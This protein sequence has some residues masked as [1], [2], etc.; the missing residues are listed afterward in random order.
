MP[1]EEIFPARLADESAL[2]SSDR[3]LRGIQAT[4][5]KIST[6]V[7]DEQS[8]TELSIIDA[9]LS[10]LASRDDTKFYRDF[11]RAERLLLE[12]GLTLL[13]GNIGADA[14]ALIEAEL[15]TSLPPE[16]D[17]DKSYDAIT[18]GIKRV[19]RH[20]AALVRTAHEDSSPAIK[21]FLQRITAQENEFHLHRAQI[22][23]ARQNLGGH[24]QVPLTVEKLQDYLVQRAPGRPGLPPGLDRG[25]G[26][27][28][29]GPAAEPQAGGD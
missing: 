27:R 21:D 1:H 11:Y 7:G 29:H 16:I 26:G 28:R 8:R 24:A 14:A 22:A 23:Q 6:L 4:L 12:A 9:M 18:R 3:L 13:R 10:E 5:Q 2:P 17:A 20:L 25:S 15:T 19:M